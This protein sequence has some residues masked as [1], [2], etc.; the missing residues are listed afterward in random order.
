MRADSCASVA[1]IHAIGPA[2]VTPIARLLGMKVIV[3]HHGRDYHRAKWNWLARLTLRAGEAMALRFANRII[4]VSPS[5]A[6]VLRER[7][8]PCAGRIVYIP[9][10][11]DHGDA[12]PAEHTLQ[13]LGLTPGKYVLG[14]GRLVPE[15]RFEDLIAAMR[16]ARPD[17]KLV[18]AGAAD[19]RD[20]YASKL[21]A[22]A[23]KQ[24]IF[25]G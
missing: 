10:G 12:A 22:Q 15:K 2:L 16:A 6:N 21:T 20:A 19:H 17:L 11:A 1:H 24:I 4:V 23:D 3:T 5:L 8:P 25:A 7:H 18:I 14:V 9:N 13:G